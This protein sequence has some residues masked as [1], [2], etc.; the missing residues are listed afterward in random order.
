MTQPEE[1]P[2]TPVVA[3]FVA[4]TVIMGLSIATGG[5]MRRLENEPVEWLPVVVVSA[6]QWWFWALAAPIIFGLSRRFPLTGRAVP[7]SLAV[8]AAAAVATILIHTL[9]VVAVSRLAYPPHGP[10]ASWGRWLLSF[11]MSRGLFELIAYAGLVA[12]AQAIDSRFHLKQREVAALELEAELA[13]AQLHALQMQLQPHFLFNTLHAI[14]VLTEEDPPKASRMIAA[15]GDLLR[16]TLATQSTQEISLGRE[17]ELLARY[18]EIETTRFPDR[19]EV[20]ID[21]PAEL[22]SLLVPTFL[23]QPLVEN[24]I[25]YGIALHPVTGTVRVRARRNGAGLELSV[26]NDGSSLPAGKGSGGVGL[27]TTRAR[28]TR[29]YGAAAGL[30]LRSGGDDGVEALA[31]LPAHHEP[32]V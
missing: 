12:L 23:L 7:R 16:A 25:R 27:A 11:V 15:L 21:V 10:D 29:L 28:L 26:W 9:F 5:T 1:A 24:A 32:V 18:L 30:D 20:A 6:S 19:L 3:L 4:C 31:W 17:L 14:G 2:R 13:H 22:Q 8:H